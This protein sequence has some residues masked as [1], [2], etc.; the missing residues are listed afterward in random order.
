MG[1]SF[2]VKLIDMP[3]KMVYNETQLLKKYEYRRAVCGV[4]LGRPAILFEMILKK[5]NLEAICAGCIVIMPRFVENDG[6][7]FH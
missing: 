4:E 5:K 6:G 7:P 3:K 1:I 2:L